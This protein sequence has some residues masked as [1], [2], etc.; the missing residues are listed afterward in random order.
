MGSE[1]YVGLS[2]VVV[3]ISKFGASAPG[4]IVYEKLGLTVQRVVDEA[5]KVSHKVAVP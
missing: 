2:G 3:G 4:K 5:M 1:R